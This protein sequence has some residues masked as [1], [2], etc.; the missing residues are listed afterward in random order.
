MNLF[1]AHYLEGDILNYESKTIKLAMNDGKIFDGILKLYEES[2][3]DEEM[4]LIELLILGDTI[5]FEH[6]NFFL[7]LQSLRQHLEKKHI[8]VMCNG[9][10]LNV[11]PSQMQGTGHLAYKLK[12]GEPARLKDIVDI[13]EFDNGL[14]FVKIEEQFSYY[15][16]WLKS[17]EG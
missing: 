8:Q 7:V 4:V 11:Y 10:A 5:S 1:L 3:D 6:E 15:N 16:K 2:P 13:F 9:A 12:F 17:L 14:R